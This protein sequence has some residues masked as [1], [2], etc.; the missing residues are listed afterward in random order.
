[1]HGIWG[2]HIFSFLWD[3]CPGVQLLGDIGSICLAFKETAR[4]FFRVN[5]LFLKTA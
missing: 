5:P 3:A 1:M 4:L 2:G